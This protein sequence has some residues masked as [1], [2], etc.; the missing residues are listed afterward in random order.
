MSKQF[1]ELDDKSSPLDRGSAAALAKLVGGGNVGKAQDAITRKSKG[2]TVPNTIDLSTSKINDMI[3]DII[4]A[5][6]GAVERLLRFHQEVQPEKDPDQKV[7]QEKEKDRVSKDSNQIKSIESIE[8]EN[9]QLL[10]G[11]REFDSSMNSRAQQVGKDI[12]ATTT[13]QQFGQAADDVEAGK[14]TLSGKA[15]EAIKPYIKYISFIMTQPELFS[16]FKTLIM[17]ANK[18]MQ[19]QPAESLDLSDVRESLAYGMPQES[20]ES[21]NVTYSKTKK[22]GDAQ[23]TISA[24]AKSMQELHDVLKLAGITLPQSDK[25][26]E[27]EPEHDHDE[28][29]PFDKDGDDVCDGC[30]REIVDG[31]CGCDDHDHGGEDEAPKASMK[32]AVRPEMS[33]DKQLLV[34]YLKDKLAK[35]LS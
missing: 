23:V 34:N 18:M 20:D 17:Q 32:L 8:L 15:L 6:P 28:V 16:K 29:D 26:S 31:E 13:G 35:S 4:N 3:V 12:G 19:S 24:N 33:T 5:G 2:E 21:E 9:L 7:D 1:F 10:A 30:G 22:D 11:L 25:P 27:E 14:A